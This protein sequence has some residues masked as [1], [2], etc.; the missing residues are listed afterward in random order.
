MTRRKIPILIVKMM[1][2]S[3][4]FYSI[5]SMLS[6]SILKDIFPAIGRI[7]N[8]STIA[9]YF[10]TL[11]TISLFCLNK[12]NLIFIYLVTVFLTVNLFLSKNIFIMD[13]YVMSLATYLVGIDKAIKTMF[14]AQLFTLSVIILSA[15]IGFLPNQ[16]SMR[17]S[18]GAVRYSLGFINPNDVAHYCYAVIFKWLFIFWHKVKVYQL[19]LILLPM[20]FI[21]SRTD[22][23]S[24]EH[25]FYAAIIVIVVGILFRERTYHFS[26]LFSKRYLLPLIIILAIITLIL[27]SFYNPMS[28]QWYELDRL[29]S[30][31]ISQSSNFLNQYGVSIVGQKLL[32]IGSSKAY[33]LGLKPLVLD[34]GFMSLWIKSGVIVLLLFIY[35]NFW[36]LKNYTKKNLYPLI[37]LVGTLL[38]EGII[39][40]SM[41]S[42]QI[43]FVMLFVGARIIGN[44]PKKEILS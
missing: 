39:N 23:R 19:A 40:S 28:I 1:T 43:N 10:V 8:F 7:Y 5:I 20:L 37:I 42:W 44:I 41:I 12:K 13:I 4:A 22:S 25:I 18:D 24:T 15:L 30:T 36:S 27:V 11:L 21:F 14:Y 2:I 34:S 26:R 32:L 9:F 29:F 6:I 3:I 33:L 17:M 16:V 31:R 38:F 35:A